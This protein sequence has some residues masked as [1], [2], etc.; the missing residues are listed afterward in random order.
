[1]KACELTERVIT[2]FGNESLEDSFHP[3]MRT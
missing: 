3:R 2:R 1:M